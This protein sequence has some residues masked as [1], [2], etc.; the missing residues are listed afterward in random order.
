M[1]QKKDLLSYLKKNL[2]VTRAIAFNRLGISELSSRIG[3]LQADGHV[4]E[5]QWLELPRKRVMQYT[6]GK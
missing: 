4:I 1:S 6:L 5:K 3:E 2:P